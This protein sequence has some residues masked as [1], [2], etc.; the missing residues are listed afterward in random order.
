MGAIIITGNLNKDEKKKLTTELASYWD[1]SLYARK[2]QQF[3]VRYVL[4]HPPFFDT[5]NLAR[6]KI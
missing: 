2:V 5:V 6:T 4:R 3:G 1:D